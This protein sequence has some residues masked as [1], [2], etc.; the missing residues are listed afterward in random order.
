MLKTITQHI[1]LT[2]TLSDQVSAYYT[3]YASTERVTPAGVV[4]QLVAHEFQLTFPPK[5]AAFP[6]CAS[7]SSTWVRVS[8]FS[9]HVS[10]QIIH[11]PCI[12]QLPCNTPTSPIVATLSQFHQIYIFVVSLILS[13]DFFFF[14]VFFSFFSF[15]ENTNFF[16]L[17]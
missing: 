3:Q 13:H 12:A 9:C 6:T 15:E 8:W 2:R 4:L 16:R 14:F 5:L 17:N 10:F 11:Q 1:L 7:C